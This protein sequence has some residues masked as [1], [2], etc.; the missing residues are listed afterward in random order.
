MIQ[1]RTLDALSVT[2]TLAKHSPKREALDFALWFQV[3]GLHFTNMTAKCIEHKESFI[4]MR[5]SR[6]E[7]H[8]IMCFAFQTK[9][10]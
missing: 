2:L 1:P 3:D 9:T 5:K 10:S 6:L 4:I 8:T 7:R